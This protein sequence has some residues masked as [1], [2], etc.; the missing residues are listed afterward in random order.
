ML[1]QRLKREFRFSSREIELLIITALVTAIIL[2]FR[3]WGE[4]SIVDI[5]S[6]IESMIL[7]SIFSFIALIIHFSGEKIYAAWKGLEVKYTI[8][9]VG[10][11][12]AIFI[13]VLFNGF[14]F[15][16]APGYLEV[17]VKE[18]A[19]LG[20][21]RYRPYIRE[22]GYLA[23]FGIFANLLVVIILGAFIDNSFIEKLVRA[24]I[25]IALF[26][27]IPAPRYDGLH[28]FFGD[29]YNYAFMAGFTIAFTVIFYQ[30][31][32]ITAIIGGILLGIAGFFFVYK[33]GF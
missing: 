28:M 12:I 24:N 3:M 14:L 18:K 20:K 16:L 9:H 21:W 10:L 19:R 25:L 2:S 33:K 32:I 11:G 31:G 13:A 1:M 30:I 29:W 22:Y 8:N 17:K 26:S 27:L 23:N 7:F 6:G 4:G 5:N 15:I